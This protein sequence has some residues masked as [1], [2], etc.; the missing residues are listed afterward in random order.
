MTTSESYGSDVTTT[1]SRR[2]HG[3]RGPLR[4]EGE[5]EGFALV[6]S[7]AF[8]ADNRT[9][10]WY[11]KVSAIGRDRGRGTSGFSGLGSKTAC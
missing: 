1:D 7:W 4:E 2:G 3:S 8:A 11:E 5:G 9:Q 10:L 6:V